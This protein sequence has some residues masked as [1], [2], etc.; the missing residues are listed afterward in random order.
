MY[1]WCHLE[2]SRF[3][4]SS[5]FRF[6]SP[7][8]TV[9][10]SG[11][12][13]SNV[14]NSTKYLSIATEKCLERQWQCAKKKIWMEDKNDLKHL[15]WHVIINSNHSRRAILPLI[16]LLFIYVMTEHWTTPEHLH[17]HVI[18]NNN[19]LNSAILPLT[20]LLA[21][22]LMT[23]LNLKHLYWH[24]LNSNHSRKDNSTTYN[25]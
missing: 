13:G 14:C 15:H 2:V 11:V 19:H 7:A 21:I 10:M 8:V 4:W 17:W 3:L 6:L 25:S 23:E 5:L 20:K 24:N 1:M 9:L 12:D 18:F 16:K 22:Y